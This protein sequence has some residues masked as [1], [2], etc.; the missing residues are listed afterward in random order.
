MNLL[1]MSAAADDFFWSQIM[2]YGC[3]LAGVYF[4]ILMKFPQVRLIKDMVNQLFSGQPAHTLYKTAFN[5]TNINC[6]INR[7][8]NIVQDIATQY[9]IFTG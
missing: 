3:L 2:I 5:L 8:P 1:S 9:F 7:L 6:R 4:S